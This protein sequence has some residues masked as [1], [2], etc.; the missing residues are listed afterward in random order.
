MRLPVLLLLFVIFCS[1]NCNKDND[2]YIP[3]VNIQGYQTRDALGN[4]IMAIGNVDDDWKL[5]NWS[6]LSTLE[7][8]FLS[9]SD[10]ISMTNTVVTSSGMDPVAYPNPLYDY[11]NIQFSSND[12]VKVKI[13][14]VDSSGHIFQTAAYKMKG[15][16]PFMFDFSNQTTYPSGK[17]LRFY[18]SFSAA[19]QANF[20]AGYGDVRVCRTSGGVSVTDCF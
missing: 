10:N 16:K 1:G 11:T 3:P 4:P 15:I 12:S 14:V 17:S 6:Q 18:Y 7:Q 13:A 19:A 8:S 20:K 2:E 5:V 9:F